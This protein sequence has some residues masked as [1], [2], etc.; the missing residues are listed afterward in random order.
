M[1]AYR[2]QAD[3]FDDLDAGM[4]QILK[5]AVGSGGSAAITKLTDKVDQRNRALAT[6][7][8]YT[9]R[10]DPVRRRQWKCTRDVR[11]TSVLKSGVMECS[12]AVNAL[13][14]RHDVAS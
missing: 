8:R 14:G 12:P 3:A 2:L 9:L 10:G 7:D 11:Q 6:A 13:S 5:A 1:L 4:L